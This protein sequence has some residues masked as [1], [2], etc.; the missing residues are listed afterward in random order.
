MRLDEKQ[1]TLRGDDMIKVTCSGDYRKTNS[2]LE[3]ISQL[4]KIDDL[5]KYGRAGVSALKAATPVDSGKTSQSWSYKIERTSNGAT[6]TWFNTNVN[7]GVNVAVILQYGHGTK[8]GKWVEG[9]DFINPAM[10][11]IFDKIADSAWK[12]VTQT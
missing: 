3:K 10:K 7:K 9:V 6:I 5:D 11:P 2:F 4:S 12:E 1:Q 8:N